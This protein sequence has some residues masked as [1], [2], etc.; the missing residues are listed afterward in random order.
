[1]KVDGNEH[2]TILTTGVTLR[3]WN[4]G[5]NSCTGESCAANGRENRSACQDKS[6]NL[7]DF[8]PDTPFLASARKIVQKPDT[9]NTNSA[10]KSFL[11]LFYFSGG[12]DI[13][14]SRIPA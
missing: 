6:Y 3:V 11:S 9:I 10:D 1:M 4:V 5:K 2:A 8:P 14:R 7:G 12:E 13:P